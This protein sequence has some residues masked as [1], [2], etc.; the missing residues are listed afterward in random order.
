MSP[1]VTGESAR[2]FLEEKAR[3]DSLSLK[4]QKDKCDR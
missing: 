2:R 1:V 3:V 4:E